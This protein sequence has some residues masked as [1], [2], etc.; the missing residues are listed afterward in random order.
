MLSVVTA[1]ALMLFNVGPLPSR[2]GFSG[3]S[4]EEREAVRSGNSQLSLA[5]IKHPLSKR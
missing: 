3:R 5:L 2:P 4:P 1:V